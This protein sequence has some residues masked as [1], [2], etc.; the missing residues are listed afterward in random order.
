[1][2]D[3]AK[4]LVGKIYPSPSQTP[5]G[6]R[7]WR[8]KTT[9]EQEQLNEF[10]KGEEGFGPFRAYYYDYLLGEFP[11]FDDAKD[12]IDFRRQA[13]PKS[14]THDWRIEDGT[15]EIVWE[16]HI[17]QDIDAW[18]RLQKFQYRPDLKQPN[19]SNG[20]QS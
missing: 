20:P 14:A 10:A 5:A 7:F 9:W 15:G 6:E 16:Y 11:T 17:S 18:R 12:E 4:E 13:D 1:M 19:K 3:L 8:G 2:Y